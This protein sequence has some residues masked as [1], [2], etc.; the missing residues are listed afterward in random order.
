[1]QQRMTVLTT[2][3]GERLLKKM[4]ENLAGMQYQAKNNL[5]RTVN[6]LTLIE[7]S[8]IESYTAGENHISVGGEVIKMP[9][10]TSFIYTCLKTEDSGY[11]L[12]WGISLS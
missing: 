4:V 12:E 9:F 7:S 8:S 3:S 5:G 2:I 1:M 6:D 10:L 11:R